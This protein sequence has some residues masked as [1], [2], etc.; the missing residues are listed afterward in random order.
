MKTG[1]WVIGGL[2]ATSITSIAL[3][4]Y[5]TLNGS[6]I[7]SDSTGQIISVVATN[8]ADEQHFH[9]FG[10][11]FFGIQS[12]EGVV[13]VRCGNGARKPITYITRGYQVRATASGKNP[14]STTSAR[15]WIGFPWGNVA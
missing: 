7:V 13:E 2:A 6:L 10:R 15:V 9:Q 1:V 11:T 4:A 5:V 14:C 3:V 8:S 12:V